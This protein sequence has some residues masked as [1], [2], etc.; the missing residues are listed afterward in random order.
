MTPAGQSNFLSRPTTIHVLVTR[1]QGKLS[2]EQFK[3]YMNQIP[4]EGQVEIL[5][6]KRWRNSQLRLLGRLLLN[7]GL[8]KYFDLKPGVLSEIAYTKFNRP[9]FPNFSVDFNI[10]HAGDCVVCG[11]AG[12][13]RVGVDVEEVKPVDP[14][15]CLNALSENELQSIQRSQNPD[16]KFCSYWTRKEAVVKA[17]GGGKVPLHQVT[18]SQRD[19][20]AMLFSK[21]WFLHEIPLGQDYCGHLAID[22]R[23]SKNQISYEEISFEEAGVNP[24]MY[25]TL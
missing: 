14:G 17:D 18:F 19:S 7:I 15:A 11:M 13:A 22:K 9:Y 24:P 1:L 21:K 12:D 8:M 3:R 16:L 4:P 2:T 10:S 20:E 6:S 5:K 23:V 25:I